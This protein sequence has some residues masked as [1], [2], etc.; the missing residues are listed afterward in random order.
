MAFRSKDEVP[1]V[2]FFNQCI[3]DYS[4]DERF[5]SLWSS[6][7]VPDA[8]ELAKE[9]EKAGLKGMEEIDGGLGGRQA[10]PAAAKKKTAKRNN[11][12]IKI[13]NTHIEGLD[14]SIPP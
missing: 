11:R 9:L 4:I 10:P 2:I 13:T 12:R 5:K 3:P 7:T 14:F 6:Q 1:K 8:A